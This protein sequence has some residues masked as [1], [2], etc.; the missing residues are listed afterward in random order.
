MLVLA[1]DT[2]SEHGGVAIFRGHECLSQI[3]NTSSS[4]YSVTLFRDVETAL[5]EAGAKISRSPL[6]LRD[7]E[8]F[9]AA[10]G[11][12]SFTG[13]RTGL[14]ATQGWATGL[15][16]P[17]FAVSIL[18]AMIHAGQPE[19]EWAAA[20]MDARRGELYVQLFRRGVG[21]NAGRFAPRSD[22]VVLRRDSVPLFLQEQLPS[23]SAITC[24]S[25]EQDAEAEALRRGLADSFGWKKVPDFLAAS[26]ARLAVEAVQRGESQTPAQIDACYIRRSD[27]ELNWK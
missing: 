9:A 24:I 16:R 2:T 25:C 11:P 8:L 7:I 12:G 1:I 26:I 6:G 22:G 18:E 4:G 19:T 15:G 21:T 14:A 10:T 5:S 23:A 27:A 3:P 17:V 20:M 13:I